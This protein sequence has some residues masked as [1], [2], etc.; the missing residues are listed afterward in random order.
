M[1][2]CS[3]FWVREMCEF[4]V[5]VDGK[6]VFKDVIYAKVEDGKV[7]VRNILGELR[8][9]R[10]HRIEEVDVNSTRLVLSAI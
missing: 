8:E 5:I 10:N 2:F 1:T 6:I 9:Y 3:R 7:A 4:D